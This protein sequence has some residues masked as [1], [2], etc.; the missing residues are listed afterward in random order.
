MPHDLVFVNKGESL[1]SLGKCT[2]AVQYFN[3]AL[4]IIRITPVH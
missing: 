1:V 4:E 3:R 2:D